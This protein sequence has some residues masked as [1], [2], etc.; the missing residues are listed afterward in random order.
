MAASGRNFWLIAAFYTSLGIKFENLKLDVT[1]VLE[2]TIIV[3][4][5]ACLIGF[6]IAELP[7]WE[8]TE[9]AARNIFATIDE[10]STM[11]VRKPVIPE[12]HVRLGR[13]ELNNVN[14]AYQPKSPLILT[15][16][17][18]KVPAQGRVGLV[19]NKGSGR[20][21]IAYLLRRF[22]ELNETG[23]GSITIDGIDVSHYGPRMLRNKIQHLP[24]EPVILNMS[25][26]DNI[27]M[28]RSDAN[29]E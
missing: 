14:F 25:I 18:L 29:D 23:A 2:T 19:G 7:S 16:L 26:K 24:Q 17:S 5:V 22:Y 11:D 10:P 9:R 15:N 12:Y 27:K 4:L 28:G 13:V 1:A 21:T 8:K 6:R 3:F 20:T